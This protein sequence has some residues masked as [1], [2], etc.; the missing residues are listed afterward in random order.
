MKQLFPKHPASLAISGT[1]ASVASLSRAEIVSYYRKHYLP[2]AMRVIYCG[3]GSVVPKIQ[4]RFALLKA[5][6]VRH[7]FVEPAP[8]RARMVL[9]REIGQSYF[10]LGFKTVSRKHEDS[11]ALDVCRA[12]LGRGLTGRIVYEIRQQRGMAYEV[13][14]HHEAGIDYGF[15]AVY[16]NTQKKNLLACEQII[17]KHFSTLAVV[18]DQELTEAKN[19]VEG[20]FLMAIEDNRAHADAL[21]AWDLSGMRAGLEDYTNQ[22]RRVRRQDVA[23]IAKKYFTGEFAIAVIE[24]KSG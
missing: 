9:R 18:S 20:E 17:R 3:P 8:G 1:Q 12:I 21:A 24:Q 6:A 22:V 15:F 4:Q 13:G 23:R 10:V 11:Y 5:G 2:G 14:C 19:F 16:L 7:S